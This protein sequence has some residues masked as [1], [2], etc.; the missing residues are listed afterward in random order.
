MAKQEQK[1]TCI[2]CHK[3]YDARRPFNY[4]KKCSANMPKE[5]GNSYVV[6]GFGSKGNGAHVT[7]FTHGEV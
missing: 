6:A 1:K 2:F 5:P 4:C 7:K 3:E